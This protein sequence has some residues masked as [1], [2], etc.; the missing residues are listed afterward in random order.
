MGPLLESKKYNHLLAMMDDVIQL[1]LQDNRQDI[2]KYSVPDSIPKNI[3]PVP[4]PAK[5]DIIQAHI[6]HF[7]TS[8]NNKYN[9]NVQQYCNC[10]SKTGLLY[11]SNS[12]F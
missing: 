4:K 6:T 8:A 3:A 1:Q 2:Q 11:T 10:Q 12:L 9:I 5:E 7:H